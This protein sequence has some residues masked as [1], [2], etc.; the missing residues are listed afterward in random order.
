MDRLDVEDRYPECFEGLTDQQRTAVLNSLVAGW[1]EGWNPTRAD[2]QNLC[3]Y[4]RG[5]IDW[6]EYER[7]ADA[8]AQRV[9]SEVR[10]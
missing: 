2:V 10:H 5:V 1:H 6:E 8:E 4:T 9:L 3:D 7:R